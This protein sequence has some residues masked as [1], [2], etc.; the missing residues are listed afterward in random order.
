MTIGDPVDAEVDNSLILNA[1]DPTPDRLTYT[2]G[3]TDAASF[4][5]ARRLRPAAAPRLP[6]T[7]RTRT[8]TQVTVTATDPGGN[9]AATVNVTIKVDRTS[10]KTPVLDRE[11]RRQMYA[12][13]GTRNR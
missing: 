6:W 9:L 13:N 4:S 1:G 3:G 7:T 8:P 12:E 11:R 5:L 2:L 10:T